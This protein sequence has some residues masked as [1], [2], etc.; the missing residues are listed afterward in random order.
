MRATKGLPDLVPDFQVKG[1][2]VSGIASALGIVGVIA[3]RADERV[4]DSLSL[5]RRQIVWRA[6]GRADQ[7]DA[8]D[9]AFGYESLHVVTYQ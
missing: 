1:K 4:T 2:D 5:D 6:T 3:N 8:A 9:Q 7:N